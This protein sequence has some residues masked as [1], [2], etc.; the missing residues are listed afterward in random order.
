MSLHLAM[1]LSFLWDGMACSPAHGDIVRKREINTI[2]QDIIN[3]FEDVRGRYMAHYF[4]CFTNSIISVLC[5]LLG[6]IIDRQVLTQA[7]GYVVLK[8]PVYDM[9]M[10]IPNKR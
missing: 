9:I 2:Q 1:Q 7:C 5:V 3:H 4:I 6:L 10:T 8:I